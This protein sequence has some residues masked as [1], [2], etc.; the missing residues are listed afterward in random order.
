MLTA[1]RTK[2]NVSLNTVCTTR[3]YRLAGSANPSLGSSLDRPVPIPRTWMRRVD[4]DHRLVLFGNVRC[5]GGGGGDAST[6]LEQRRTAKRTKAEQLGANRSSK[7]LGEQRRNRI[8]D[9]PVND[10]TTT[11]HGDV[12]G[13]RL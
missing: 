11:A 8:P 3:N 13:E 12:I 6:R 10:V 1:S 9:L 4:A 2:F 5:F 7:H